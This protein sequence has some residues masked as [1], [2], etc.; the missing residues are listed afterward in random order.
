MKMRRSWIWMGALAAVCVGAF[1]HADLNQQL[2][3]LLPDDGSMFQQFGSS[4]ATSGGTAVIGN[5]GVT[6]GGRP[7]YVFN[8]TTG[9]QLLRLIPNGGGAPRFGKSVSLSGTIAVVGAHLDN[10]NGDDSGSAYVFDVTTGQQLFKL[11]ANDGDAGDH[12]GISVAV[13]GTIAV[14]GARSD[15]DN[16]DL[17]GSAYV[18]D[19]TTGQQLFKLLPDDGDAD[20][21]FGASVAVSGTFAIIG[22]A[23]DEDNGGASGSAYVFDVTTGQQLFKLL[24]NDSSASGDRFGTSVAIDGTVAVIGALDDEEAGSGSGSAY[25][26]DVTTGLQLFELLAI[27][28]A[29]SDV[30]G[31][32]VAVSGN[33]AVISAIGDDDN[34]IGSGSAYIFDVTTGRQLFKLLADDGAEADLFGHSVA[35]SDTTALVGSL[36]DDDNGEQSGSA[37]VFDISRL[38]TTDL[39]N[40]GCVG[41]ADMA[42]LL[43]A[44]GAG[45]ATDFDCDGLTGAADLALLLGTWGAGCP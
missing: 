15:D 25:V 6:G 12:F 41:A 5:G 22:A 2:F 28:L 34:G 32:S 45:G 4:V 16:G 11:L 3:K 29:H 21:L 7:P 18:F 37:Y 44:W 8:V 27:D 13:S 39:N 24:A 31:F 40:D 43:G 26:F 30:F 38:T 42:Q 35:V 33:S 36:W 19:V 1:A 17:S 23:E 10:D 14:I 20:D 9:Q